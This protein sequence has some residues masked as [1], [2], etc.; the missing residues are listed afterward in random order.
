MEI[1]DI[2]NIGLG[3]F[4]TILGWMLHTLWDAVKDLQ[5]ADKQITNRVSQIEVL[6]AG[7]YIT[8]AEWAHQF[9]KLT[10]TLDQISRKLDAKADK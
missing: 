5:A 9:D 1:Q 4:S 7:K 10:T 8:R 6:V 3:L 2:V